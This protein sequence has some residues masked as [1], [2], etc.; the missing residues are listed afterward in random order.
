[1]T[2]SYRAIVEKVISRGPHGPY[3]IARSD[4]LEGSVT[5]SL[6]SKVWQEKS[7]PD[8]GTCVILT[9]IRKKRAGWRAESARF[10]KPSDEAKPQATETSNKKEQ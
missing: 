7:W 3:A 5:F 6:D 9:E 10:V 1:M 4:A 8:A 2:E